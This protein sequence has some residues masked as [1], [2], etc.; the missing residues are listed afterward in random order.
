[1][2]RDAIVRGKLLRRNQR[3]SRCSRCS[4]RTVF[5]ADLGEPL[6]K[7]WC[8]TNTEDLGVWQD[9]YAEEEYWRTS[10]RELRESKRWWTSSD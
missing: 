6:S 4:P 10:K 3:C 5:A 9:D 1:M 8:R 2:M 7:D